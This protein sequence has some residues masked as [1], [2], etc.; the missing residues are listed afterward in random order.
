MFVEN[1]LQSEAVSYGTSDPRANLR[2]NG[3]TPEEIEFLCDRQA[4]AGYAGRRV[5]LNS[6]TSDR[7]VA[8]IESKLKHHGIVKVMPSQ[9]DLALAYRRAFALQHTREALKDSTAEAVAAAKAAAIPEG[10]MER[11]AKKL[12]ENP[13]M[14]WDAALGSAFDEVTQ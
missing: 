4:W 11:V 5:E 10:L 14:P 6:F 3:A 12:A 7:L 1:N 9:E 2:E 13:E 8:W